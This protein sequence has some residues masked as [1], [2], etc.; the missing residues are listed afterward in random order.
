MKQAKQIIV[1]TFLSILV[2]FSVFFLTILY[3]INPLH[4]FNSGETYSLNLGFPF[5]Y[6]EQFWLTGSKIPNS[7]W[8][9]QNL[10]YDCLL[11]LIFVTGL[12][13]LKPKVNTQKKMK[14]SKIFQKWIFPNI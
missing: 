2:F 13:F 5:K 11:T 9:I 14:F 6:Y 12:Y 10:I 8:F 4:Y 3:Q 7:S 1:E